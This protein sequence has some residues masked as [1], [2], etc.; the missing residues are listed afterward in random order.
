MLRSRLLLLRCRNGKSWCE[1]DVFLCRA[2][3]AVSKQ[4]MRGNDANNNGVFKSG[5]R[6]LKPFCAATR[7]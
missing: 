3:R 4:V 6:V 2:A 5:S 7:F 1:V